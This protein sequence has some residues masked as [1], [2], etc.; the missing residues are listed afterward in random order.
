M[1]ELSDRGSIPLSSIVDQTW[2]KYYVILFHNAYIRFFCENYFTPS[3]MPQVWQH[4]STA[5]RKYRKRR[6]MYAAILSINGKGMG[7]NMIKD[8]VMWAVNRKLICKTTNYFL[9]DYEYAYAAG[10]CLNLKDA[11]EA[12]RQSFIQYSEVAEL[13]KAVLEF[14]KEVTA[15]NEKEKNLFFMLKEY[16]SEGK[17]TEE[18]LELLQEGMKGAITLTGF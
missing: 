1:E 7:I 17:M 13:Q 5:E 8:I 15:E 14:V 9:D 16:E 18:K 2:Y 3:N 4:V 12:I 6:D 11:K 10:L